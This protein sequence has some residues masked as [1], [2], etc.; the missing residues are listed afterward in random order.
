MSLAINVM[1][2]HAAFSLHAQLQLPE[3][4][5]TCLFGP[6]GCGKTTLLRIIAGL[7]RSATGVVQW[8]D[9]IWQNHQCFIPPHRRS[10]GY[11][12]QEASLFAH[13]TVRRNLLYG[14]RR[15]PPTDRR[16]TLDDIIA[17]FELQNLLERGVDTLSGG[18]K[19]RVAMARALAISPALLLMDEPLAALDGDHKRQ[20]I[21]YLESLR[22]NLDLPILYVSHAPAEVVR[23][24]DHLVVMDQGRILASGA[25]AEML[26]RLDLPLARDQ[27]AGALVE[28]VVAGHEPDYALTQLSFSGGVLTIRGRDLPIGHRVRLRIAASDVSLT[29]EH[30]QGTS[31]QNIVPVTIDQIESACEAHRLV[32]LR[33]GETVLLARV[34]RKSADLLG[35]RP[36]KQVFA[37]VKSVVLLR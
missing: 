20:I 30:Q 2:R 4:G 23:L 14:Y 22:E 18:E 1:H 5:V 9:T 26:T 36:G 13:L 32:R 24:A 15:V 28:A 3:R 8:G 33:A 17:R 27:D 21:P 25:A 35:L 31:I 37:L 12:F 11:V 29:L 16:F 19:Q 7:E 6:S 34:T 10:V